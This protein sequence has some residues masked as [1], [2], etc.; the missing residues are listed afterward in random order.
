[1]KPCARCEWQPT[2]GDTLADHAAEHPLCGCCSQ[3][4]TVYERTVCDPCY[5]QAQSD[6]AGI[7]VMYAE[8]PQHLGHVR[9]PN[10]DRGRS[11]D[12]PMPGGDVLVLLGKGSQGL[13]EDGTTTKDND[14]PSVAYELGWW[15]IAWQDQ[16]GEHVNVSTTNRAVAYLTAT[17]RW[18][19]TSYD[20]FAE[21]ATD[22]RTLHGRLEAATARRRNP[23]RAGADC[24]Q[25]GGPLVRLVDDD[26]FEQDQVTCRDCG[27][28][29][30]PAG[31]RLALRA[32]AE[33]VA[34]VEQDGETYGTPAVLARHLG[35]SE[36]TIRWW[37]R[38]GQVRRLT[39]GG[40]VYCHAA[41]TQQADAGRAR[42]KAG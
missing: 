21:Y 19:A 36:R 26:G 11:T 31:Y 38:A 37:A 39:T 12:S 16:R 1:V 28:R 32:A 42:R 6:L 30:T 9:S 4:L 41:D 14:P 27:H 15:A 23:T 13:A 20:G 29:L 25:C 3:S 40:V 22:L 2:D 35:R 10:Y 34:W 7:A 8:L 5:Q 33:A 17:A 18:A 24:F